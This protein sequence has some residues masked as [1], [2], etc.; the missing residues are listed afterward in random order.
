M[1]PKTVCLLLPSV[2]RTDGEKRHYIGI[3]Y[4]LLDIASASLPQPTWAVHDD[5]TMATWPLTVPATSI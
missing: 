5:Y 1:V 3:P 4:T 2:L